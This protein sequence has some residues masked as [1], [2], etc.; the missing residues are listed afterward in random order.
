[1]LR[2]GTH[3]GHPHDLG[4][5][6]LQDWGELWAQPEH[7]TGIELWAAIK[8]HTSNVVSN[9]EPITRDDLDRGFKMLNISTAI[10]IDQWSPVQ[11]RLL[12]DRAK[13]LLVEILR[14][15]YGEQHSMARLCILQNY[16]PHGQA[17]RWDWTHS[18]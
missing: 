18:P 6:F 12:R 4:Q 15:R 5:F 3:Y 14:D 1:M 10:F 9:K 11:P 2:N 16:C 13:D 17:S 7:A 8:E